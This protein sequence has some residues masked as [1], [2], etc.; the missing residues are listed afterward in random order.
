MR[1]IPILKYTG[2]A[3]VIFGGLLNVWMFVAQ[4]FPTYLFFII[5]AVGLVIWLLSFFLK[6][7]STLWQFVVAAIP[8]IIAWMLWKAS[9][10]SKDIFLIPKNFIGEVTI[11]YDQSTGQDPEY[12]GK[13]RV[14]KIPKNGY[15][16]TRFK[17][18]GGVINLSGS[19]YYY[20]DSN[21]TRMELHHFCDYC[22]DKDTVSIQVLYGVLG[23]DQKGTFQTFYVDKPMNIK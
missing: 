22:K 23:S 16:E 4:A 6:N 11:Y 12:E 19:R 2:L 5:M 20:L 1:P 8:F 7:L 13:W 10:P 9:G 17:L 14:Y 15:L 18:K 3:L 21:G